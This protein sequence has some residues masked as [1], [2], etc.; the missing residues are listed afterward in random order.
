MTWRNWGMMVI[1]SIRR[2]RNT[3]SHRYR[4]AEIA[5]DGNNILR[6]SKFGCSI[7]T[8][9]AKYR[10][11]PNDTLSFRFPIFDKLNQARSPGLLRI[12]AAVGRKPQ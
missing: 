7:L 11:V 2:E 5:G 10:N 12:R 6:R 9:F 1:P 4:P 8:G 3:L